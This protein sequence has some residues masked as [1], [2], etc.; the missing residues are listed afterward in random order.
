MF[1]EKYEVTFSWEPLSNPYLLLWILSNKQV[2][3][4][5]MQ[6]HGT[7]TFDSRYVYSR[8]HEKC[9][10][11]M[12]FAISRA[13]GVRFLNVVCPLAFQCRIL[14]YST[15]KTREDM[16]KRKRKVENDCRV[17]LRKPPPQLISCQSGL[18]HPIEMKCFLVHLNT[19]SCRKT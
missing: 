4:S 16:A 15:A 13:V 12:Y 19:H 2:L 11:Q 6:W 17:N 7:I 18:P 9:P 14:N 5:Y 3:Y 8:R 1:E 10:V